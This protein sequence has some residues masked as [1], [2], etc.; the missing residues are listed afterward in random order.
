[1]MVGLALALKVTAAGLLSQYHPLRSII[2]FCEKSKGCFSNGTFVMDVKEFDYINVIPLV[3]AM[4]VLLTIVLTTSTLIAADQSRSR[5]PRH[6]GTG[7]TC[8]G[9]DDRDRPDRHDLL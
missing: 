4:L 6:P 9:L 5:C 2:S 7:K 1:M 8:C 3:D